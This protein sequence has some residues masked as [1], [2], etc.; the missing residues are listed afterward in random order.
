MLAH[1]RRSIKPFSQGRNEHPGGDLLA[2]L[3]LPPEERVI[4]VAM[5]FGELICWHKWRRPPRQ[6]AEA[7]RFY[8][9]MID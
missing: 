4:R 1:E 7:A 9:Q 6:A 5:N 3:L 2:P 8:L